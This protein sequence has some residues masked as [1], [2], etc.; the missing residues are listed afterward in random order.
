MRVTRGELDR[1]SPRSQI[2]VDSCAACSHL[3]EAHFQY[4]FGAVSRLNSTSRRP[5]KHD[6]CRGFRANKLPG[7][8]R[9]YAV[10][11]MQG[12]H[13]IL[14]WSNIHA[15][16]QG[17]PPTRYFLL[18]W[19]GSGRHGRHQV[20]KVRALD[21]LGNLYLTGP[22]AVPPLS[23]IDTGACKVPETV[24][25]VRDYTRGPYLVLQCRLA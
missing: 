23:P 21:A 15:T 13:V 5:V 17:I 25:N 24:P 19:G 12:I 6:I 7:Q 1:L 8:H 3:C 10:A 14:V 18:R 16:P 2:G 9:C 11:R 4:T 22:E 20:R